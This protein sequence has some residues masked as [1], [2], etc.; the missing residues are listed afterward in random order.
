MARALLRLLLIVAGAALG[1]GLGLASGL[2][3]IETMRTSCF[4]GYCG[5]VVVFHLLVG[6]GLGAVAGGVLGGRLR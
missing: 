1:G 3:W 6:V 4:E 2:M 5:Y